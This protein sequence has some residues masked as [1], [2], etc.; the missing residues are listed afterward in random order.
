MIMTAT[1]S[2]LTRT[3]PTTP[4]RGFTVVVLANLNGT[5]TGE[6]TK[7]LAAVAHRETPPIPSVHKEI[8]LSKEVL[9]RYAWTYQFPHYGLKMVPEGNHLL[10]EFDNGGTLAVFPESDTKFFA[11]PWPTQFEFSKNEQ[12][13]FTV[14]RRYQDGG[15]EIGAKK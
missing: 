14:L 11:K 7:A 1:T 8:S 13:E 9:T 12:G 2:G 15:E 3:W 6:M 5:V 4:K 10:V